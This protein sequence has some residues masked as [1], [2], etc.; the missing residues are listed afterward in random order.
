VH[1]CL[2]DIDLLFLLYPMLQIHVEM[3]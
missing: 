3:N 2:L 1:P